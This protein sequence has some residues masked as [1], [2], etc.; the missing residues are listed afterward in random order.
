MPPASPLNSQVRASD[1]ERE[2][3]ASQLREHAASGRLEIEELDQRL[4]RTY[5]AR[6][7]DELAA[8][9]SD[10]P[11]LDTPPRVARPSG[12]RAELRAHLTSFVLVNTLLVA[13]WAVTGA[14]YF[15]PIWPI[16]GWGLGIASHVS[17]TLLGLSAPPGWH[18]GHHRS[19]HRAAIAGPRR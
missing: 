5:A 11:S 8:L 18:C 10:L 12:R 15:W 19:R 9:T 16:L 6:T 7:R 14:D 13:I 4:E 1:E 17:G 2:R 3:V